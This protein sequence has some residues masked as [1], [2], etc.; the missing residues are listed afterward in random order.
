LI[1]QEYDQMPQ[2]ILAVTCLLLDID[3]LLADKPLVVWP[4][5]GYTKLQTNLPG[6]GI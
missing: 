4:L 1:V 3:H 2:K 6:G 5:I